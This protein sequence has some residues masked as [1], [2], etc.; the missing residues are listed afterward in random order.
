MISLMNSWYHKI[1]Q[2][3]SQGPLLPL[4]QTKSLAII[5]LFLCFINEQGIAQSKRPSI[6]DL[7]AQSQSG[8][9]AQ[10]TA[11]SPLGVVLSFGPAVGGGKGSENTQIRYASGFDLSLSKSF[12]LSQSLGVPIALGP[13]FSLSNT[14]LDTKFDRS[15]ERY[16]GR[17]D[18]R[19]GSVGLR[20]KW[21]KRYGFWNTPLFGS[22]SGGL[23]FSKLSLSRT[24]LDTFQKID[25]NRI[26]GRSLQVEL[27]TGFE[28]TERFDLLTS[29]T[30][31]VYRL[32]QTQARGTFEGE[33]LGQNGLGLLQGSYSSEDIDDFMAPYPTLRLWTFKVGFAA[34]L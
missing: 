28:L 30:N 19:T 13:Q 5:L 2:S 24:T 18:Q 21:D 29:W 32:D 10:K 1:I 31:T 20:L 7:E 16:V 6:T 3:D 8:S 25:V 14:I 4:I 17:Y 27:G 23:T 34:S 12:S 9:L 22:V 33:T 26:N 11:T 15:E